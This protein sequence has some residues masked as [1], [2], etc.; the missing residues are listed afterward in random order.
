MDQLKEILGDR[1][2]N[3]VNNGNIHT[4]I[5]DNNVVTSN[6]KKKYSLDRSKFTPNTEE[7]QLAENLAT[8]LNDT[9]NYAFYY[10]VV[11]TLRIARAHQALADIKDEIQQKKNTKYAIKSPKKYF[12]FKYKKGLYK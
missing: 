8:F 4:S 10:S 11:K 6:D 3:N 5:N 7:A 9:E 1:K 2:Y 12:T